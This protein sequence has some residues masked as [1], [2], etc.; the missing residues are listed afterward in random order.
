MMRG[1]VCGIA[2]VWHSGSPNG[3]LICT[4]PIG[5]VVAVMAASLSK[6]LVYQRLS[7]LSGIVGKS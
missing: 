3:M 6:R 5:Q 7:S 4:G 2:T 1:I